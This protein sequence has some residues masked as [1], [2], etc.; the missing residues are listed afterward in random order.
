MKSLDLRHHA[1]I[2]MLN[3]IRNQIRRSVMSTITLERSY[4]PFGTYGRWYQ[5]DPKFECYTVERPWLENQSNI[6]CIPEGRYRIFRSQYHRGGYPCFEV[7]D[8]ENR[9]LIK[10]HIA[11]WPKDVHGCI[12]MGVEIRPLS[13]S[14]DPVL[15]V[16]S[17]SATFSK[18]MMAMEGQD[19]A[20]LDIRTYSPSNSSGTLVL[21][22]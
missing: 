10:I 19:E 7:A 3:N 6:S 9:A 20:E 8:V 11:N 2:A 5:D 12:G 14:G 13:I 16:S 18:W 15:A 4:L 22:Q 17:S 21:N 1:T